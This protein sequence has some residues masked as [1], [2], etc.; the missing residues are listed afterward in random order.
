MG[1]LVCPASASARADGAV[2][3]L[4]R[5]ADGLARLLMKCNL[6]TMGHWSGQPPLL[7]EARATG[8][9]WLE[10][11]REVVIHFCLRRPPGRPAAR[12]VRPGKVRGCR[13]PVSELGPE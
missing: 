3:G 9:G 13:R 2:C 4:Y 10:G 7:S 5:W 11:Q 8:H 1:I 12:A 6:I